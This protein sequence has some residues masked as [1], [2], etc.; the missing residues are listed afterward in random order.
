MDELGSLVE[1]IDKKLC[2]ETRH[3]NMVTESQHLVGDFIAAHG[4]CDGCSLAYQ[5][6]ARGTT[7][8][9]TCQ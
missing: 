6:E 5:P 2:A 8:C 3:V 4:Y 7:S 1:N 9:D